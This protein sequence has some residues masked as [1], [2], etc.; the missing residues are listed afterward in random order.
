[1]KKNELIGGFENEKHHINKR[2]YKLHF[3]KA[4][5]DQEKSADDYAGILKFN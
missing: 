3:E 2:R 4:E 5:K 1:M